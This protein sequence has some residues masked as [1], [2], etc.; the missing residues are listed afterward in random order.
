MEGFFIP[1]YRPYSNLSESDL[2]DIIKC[3]NDR[4]KV[5][6]AS[7]ELS[8]RKKILETINKK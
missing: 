3:F 8:L 7:E 5:K 2:L 6:Y 1:T 4:I